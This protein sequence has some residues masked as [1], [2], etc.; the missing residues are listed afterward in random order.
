MVDEVVECFNQVADSSH[1]GTCSVLGTAQVH[2]ISQG[3]TEPLICRV[4][5]VTARADA[6]QKSVGA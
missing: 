5:R 2:E 3:Q 4:A 1:I 6:D